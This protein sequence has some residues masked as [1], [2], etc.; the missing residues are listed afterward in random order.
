VDPPIVERAHPPAQGQANNQR[1]SRVSSPGTTRAAEQRQKPDDVSMIGAITCGLA[2]AC[3][4]A[5][6]DDPTGPRDPADLTY[7]A[8]LNVDFA[9]M[10]QTSTGLW[11]E[12][13]EVGT[14]PAVTA[15]DRVRVLY[16]GWLPDGTLFDSNEDPDDPLEFRV[17][18]GQVIP[19]WDEGLLDMRPGGTRK[20]VIRPGLAYGG[21]AS[22]VI[23]ANSTLVFD[24]ILLGYQ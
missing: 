2:V 1:R 18:L 7:A 6:C 11:Y 15:G 17:G 3:L 12:D 23:P 5:G 10:T 24:V 21:R 22:G 13:L 9:R 4:A 19:G 16:H 14:G 20:L 8:Q